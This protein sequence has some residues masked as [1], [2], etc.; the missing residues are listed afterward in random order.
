MTKSAW[1]M[2]V[3]VWSIVIY[4]TVKFFWMVLRSSPPSGAA[5]LEGDSAVP[6]VACPRCRQLNPA[7]ATYCAQC[8][9]PLT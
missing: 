1:V 2:L 5:P 3:A 8:G 9:G 6:A 4:F 7:P